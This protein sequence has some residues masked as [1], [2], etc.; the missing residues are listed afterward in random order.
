MATLPPHLAKKPIGRERVSPYVVDEHQRERILDAAIAV[1]AKRGYANTT[2]DNLIAAAKMGWGR[3]Y[4]YFEDKE[5][6]FAEA[7]DRVVQRSRGRIASAIPDDAPWEEQAVDALRA[8]LGVVAEEPHAARLVLVEAQ[9]AGPES[10]ARYEA[11]VE[12][13]T[14]LLRQARGSS[15]VGA[16]LPESFEDASIAGVA[17]LLHQ[18]IVA[19]DLDQ[20]EELLP[21]LVGILIEPYLG[22]RR[23][24]SLL[25]S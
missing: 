19:G 8:L 16:E 4:A 20:V 17:W 1:F 25:A 23:A 7:F 13:L 22:E 15:K 24:A 3:F 21:D 5:S 6:C 10:L 14:P 12:S 9:T 11:L 18:R 2:I